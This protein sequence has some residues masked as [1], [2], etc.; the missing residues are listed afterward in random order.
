MIPKISIIIPVYHV[1]EYITMCLQS[2]ANQTMTEGIECIIVDDCGGDNSI[3]IAEQYILSYENENHN[4][5]KIDFKIVYREQNGGLSAARNSGIKVAKG[6]YLYFL[7][8]DDEITPD[9]MESYW[10]LIE[11]YGKI[12]LVH[13]CGYDINTPKEKPSEFSLP[14]YT[15]DVNLLKNFLLTYHG[16]VICAQCKLLRR[17][18]IIN[19]ELF[20]KLGIIHEDN[21]WTFYMSKYI[22]SMAF[23]N[24][25]TYLHRDN[26]NSITKKINIDKEIYSYKVILENICT[27]IDACQKGR[28]KEFILN[29]LLTVIN[30]HYYCNEDGKQ[31][32]L[33]IFRKTQN[34]F[35][36]LLFSIYMKIPVGYCKNKVLNVLFR[37]YKLQL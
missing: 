6:E 35:E 4:K 21:Y 8:S 20:F 18:I 17:D 30:N 31:E 33:S 10:R 16:K 11:K 3:A 27:N 22:R 14:E 13:G 15:E 24:V 19:N 2:V 7:D 1:E 28:Q 34:I 23:N 26:P 25:R 32:L 36:R 9:C 12:D 37:L 5:N 29:N